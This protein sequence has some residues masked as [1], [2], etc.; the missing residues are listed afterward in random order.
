[1]LSKIKGT[2]HKLSSIYSN[3]DE[4][5]IVVD[6]E[7][8]DDINEVCYFDYLEFKSIQKRKENKWKNIIL[9]VLVLLII[10]LIILLFIFK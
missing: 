2:L 1:M 4:I 6:P 7:T 10:S 5:K 9:M 8:I 3:T